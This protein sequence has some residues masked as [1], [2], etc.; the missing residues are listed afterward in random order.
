MHELCL[1]T[2]R[3]RQTLTLYCLGKVYWILFKQEC[4]RLFQLTYSAQN[5]TTKRIYLCS[6]LKHFIFWL[7][8]VT[9]ID[10]WNRCRARF[11][12]L[13]PMT[14]QPLLFL[15]F[16]PWL[17][18]S[19]SRITNIFWSDTLKYTHWVKTAQTHWL[20][21]CAISCYHSKHSTESHTKPGQSPP[22]EHLG[23]FFLLR[24]FLTPF[25]CFNT[26]KH[27]LICSQFSLSW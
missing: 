16:C 22:E 20:A 25:P 11:R 23:F 14:C 24:T 7:T 10:R 4:D 3:D 5:H 9:W 15:Y 12:R 13:F 19:W 17:V 8:I 21:H 1:A 27:L 2:A 6:K 26:Y 18:K